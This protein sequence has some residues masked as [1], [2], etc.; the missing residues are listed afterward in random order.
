MEIAQNDRRMYSTKAA[1]EE[2][3]PRRKKYLVLS[4]TTNA[5]SVDLNTCLPI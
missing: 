1:Q 3:L 2:G 5:G 4:N